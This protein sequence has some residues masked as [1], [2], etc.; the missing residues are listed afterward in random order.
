MNNENI[1]TVSSE[2]K[3]VTLIKWFRKNDV[4]MPH[5]LIQKMVRKKSILVNDKKAKQ[6]QILEEG[7]IISPTHQ[8]WPIV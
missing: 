3:G 5:G 1:Y 8:C 2:F 7:D 6:D 4:G